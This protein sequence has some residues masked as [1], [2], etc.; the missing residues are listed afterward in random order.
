MAQQF[1][2]R[3]NSG[4]LFKND[5]KETEKHPD[6]TGTANIDGVE[7]WLSAW[8]KEGKKGKFMSLA[9]KEKEDRGGYSGGSRGSARPAARPA[10]RR[11]ENSQV[12]DDDIPF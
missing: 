10:P 12:D 9:F 11:D 7:F 3:D 6:Y 5:K 1:Q 2:Q 8:V 4:V